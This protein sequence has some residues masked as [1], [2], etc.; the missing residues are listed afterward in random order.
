MNYLKYTGYGLGGLVICFVVVGL[1]LPSK[2]HI[3][4]NVMINASPEDVFAAIDSFHEFNQWSP[5]ARLDPN[6]HYSFEGPETGLGSKMNWTSDNPK[7]GSGNSEVIAYEPNKNITV[8]IDFGPEGK[9]VYDLSLQPQ[10]DN[11]NIT[12]GFDVDFGLN[13]LAR[14]FAPFMDDIVGENYEEGLTTLKNQIEERVALRGTQ[15]P[16]ASS[17]TRHAQPTATESPMTESMPAFAEN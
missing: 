12:W 13:L 2:T 16:L 8:A 17:D 14:Y 3:E 5:W 10:N 1:F 9:A 15:Q 11:T 7:V 4:R 6:T